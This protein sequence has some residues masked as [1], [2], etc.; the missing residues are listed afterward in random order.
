MV[1]LSAVTVGKQI[2]HYSCSSRNAVTFLHYGNV[3]TLHGAFRRIWEQNNVFKANSVALPVKFGF[4]QV[5]IFC[6]R[7]CW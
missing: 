6:I 7:Y 3:L 2:L 5:G 1:L 4:V